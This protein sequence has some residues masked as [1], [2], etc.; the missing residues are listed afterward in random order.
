MATPLL[1]DHVGLLQDSFENLLR[2]MF[3]SIGN[4]QRNANSNPSQDQDFT[5]DKLPSIAEDIVYK[6]KQIDM[7][8]DQANEQTCIGQDITEIQ[9]SLREK[10]AEYEKDVASLKDRC[11]QAEKWLERIRQMLDVIAQNTPWMQH[12]ETAPQ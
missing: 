3:E 2:A 5:F 4:I 1:K 9:Q 7:L 8:I 10:S 12:C 6:V 11:D